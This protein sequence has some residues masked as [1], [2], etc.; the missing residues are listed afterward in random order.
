MSCIEI[1][2]HPIS[3]KLINKF[4]RKC[5]K[6]EEYLNRLMDE[7]NLIIAKRFH[8][9]LLFVVKILK[10]VEDIPHIIRGS[11]G[12]SL[13]CYCL[14]ITNIDPVKENI[15]FARFLNTKRETMP[16]IDMDFPYNKRELVF[17]RLHKRSPNKIGRISNHIYFQEKSAK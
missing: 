5:P 10:L 2:T 4:V 9:H 1:L 6:K 7:F 12:S 15:I 8:K 13:V 14:G 11:S 3:K 17:E 16:D